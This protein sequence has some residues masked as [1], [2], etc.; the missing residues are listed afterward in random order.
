MALPNRG[1]TASNGWLRSRHEPGVVP[2]QSV[3]GAVLFAATELEGSL[4]ANGHA[5]LQV[6]V[7]FKNASR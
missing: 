1:K 7:V 2:L 5:T 6:P 4:G 3:K